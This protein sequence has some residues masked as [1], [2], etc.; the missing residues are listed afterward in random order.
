MLV[1]IKDV[2]GNDILIS[3][4]HVA[5]V[6]QNVVANKPTTIVQMV[7]GVNFAVQPSFAEVE[8]LLKGE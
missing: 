7:N 4:N 5:S 2:N 8:T 1:K 6:Q 3:K